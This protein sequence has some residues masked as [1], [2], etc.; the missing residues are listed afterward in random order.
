MKNKTGLRWVAGALI[1]S[2]LLIWG[3]VKVGLR[4]NGTHSFPVGLYYVIPKRPEKGDL[5][6]AALPSLPIFEL[7]KA[8]GY[9]SMLYSPAGHFMKRL[10]GVGGDRVTI[11]DSGVSVNGSRLVNSAPRNT[12]EAGRP[13]P[14]YR[15]KEYVLS[16]DEV[17][18]MS[19]YNPAS[20]DSRYFG[21]L[22]A[23]TIQEVIKPL[24]TWN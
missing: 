16:R 23:S 21:P 4:I 24:L 22:Q 2:L 1:T 17:L 10:V 11:D 13:L 7:A 18:L 8:R 15:I 9:F 6:V 12:D 19:D 14:S 5:V 20:F 3:A